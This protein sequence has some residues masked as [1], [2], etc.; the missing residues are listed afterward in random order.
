MECPA[1]SHFPTLSR[2]FHEFW[3]NVTEHK[4]CALIFSK[5]TVWNISDSKRNCDRFSRKCRLVCMWSTGCSC[6]ILM[7]TRIFFQVFSKNAQMLNFMKICPL[8]AEFFHANCRTDITELIIA[9]RNFSK[10]SK[11]LS[12]SEII[13]CRNKK[14]KL[15]LLSQ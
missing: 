12:A 13:N 5:N 7:K 2:K 10:A 6:Q 14:S 11:N 3:K 15:F 1:V 4:S 8:G 9:F